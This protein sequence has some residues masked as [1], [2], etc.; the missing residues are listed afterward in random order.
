MA[1]AVGFQYDLSQH[2]INKVINIQVR[3]TVDGFTPDQK[4]PRDDLETQKLNEIIAIELAKN[5]SG[6][7]NEALALGERRKNMINDPIGTMVKETASKAYDSAGGPGINIGTTLAEVGQLFPGGQTFEP[8]KAMEGI[9]NTGAAMITGRNQA[10]DQAWQGQGDPKQ[11]ITDIGVIGTDLALAGAVVGADMPNTKFNTRNA[12]FNQ[13]KKNPALGF[14]T[15]VGTNVAAKQAGNMVYDL[16]NDMARQIM[17]LPDPDAAYQ[18]NENI[19]NLMDAYTELKWS[20]GAMG[21]MHVFPLVKRLMGKTLRVSDDMKI[22]V[23]ETPDAEGVMQPINEN[24]LALAKQYNIPMNVFSTSP[25]GFV[26]G[27]GSVI[28]LFPFVATKA[29]LAQNAQQVALAENI[30][31]VLNDLSPIGL[32]SDSNIIAT[33]SFK[34]MIKKFTATKTALYNRALRMADKVKDPFIPTSRIKEMAENLELETYG[35]KRPTGGEGQIRLNNPDPRRPQTV[36]EALAAFTGKPDEFVDALID[37]QHL[38]EFVT[39]REF[40]KLQRHF[41]TMKRVAAGEAKFGTD[42]GGVDNFTNAMIHTLN[43]F[44]NFR[45]FDD[46]AKQTLVN[47]FSGSM[48]IANDYFFNNVNYTKGRVAQILGLGDKNIAKATDDVDPTMLTG[49]QVLKILFNDE[50]MYSPA[51][52]REMK[53]AMPAVKINGKT[54]D[55]VKAVARSYIDD[56]LRSTTKYIS[57]DLSVIGESSAGARGFGYITGKEPVK[58]Q[59]V[60]TFNIPIIDIDALR[61]AFGLDNPNKT[62][63]MI[64][65]FGKEQHNRIRNVLALGEQIQQTSF[66]DV[67]AFVKR[68]G[69]LGGIN[70]ITN[71]AFAGFVANNPFGNVGLVLAARYGMSKMADPKFMNGLTKVMNPEL[72]DL[73]RKQALINTI[74]LSPE[75]A[76]GMAE[77]KE[78]IPP[79]LQNLDTGNPYDVMKYLIFGAENNVSY[80]GAENMNIIIGPNGYAQDVELSKVNSQNEFSIDAQGVAADM[81]TVEAET[82]TEPDTPVDTPKRDPFLDV[83]FDEVIQQSDAGMGIEKAQ[84]RLTEDQRIALAGG[85]LDQAIA[86]GSRGRV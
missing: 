12:I 42:L 39:G 77:G 83:N 1:E 63:A 43:D 66:G 40:K 17:Q 2:G 44:E 54:V 57:G 69:F 23:G 27:A 75:L 70:A 28:G 29:R 76:L 4:F 67:S 35:G 33:K 85:N 37:M 53:A 11:I 64:E 62:Q 51:A 78:D 47:Q 20:G 59:K 25:S 6:V 68:R 5:K 52:I 50:T 13:I 73:A 71:L 22:K 38:P 65:I 58:S 34:T 45:Q 46:K 7:L 74:A 9:V 81:Q 18:N 56:N 10:I 15:I 3:A 80:P 36:D 26:K 30:N 31:A 79:E 19:R 24:M 16:M 32:F 14:A 49:E 61:G 41:N 55:P 21:L 84:K 48:G 72:S 86:M 8:G 60:G 82:V